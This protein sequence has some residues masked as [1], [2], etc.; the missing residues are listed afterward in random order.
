MKNLVFVYLQ[1]SISRELVDM[2]RKQWLSVILVQ[3]NKLQIKAI[4]W[5]V[6]SDVFF[7]VVL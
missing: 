3:N 6:F 2:A 4:C 7:V 1:T 5:C